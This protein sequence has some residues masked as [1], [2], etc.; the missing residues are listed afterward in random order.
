MKCVTSKSSVSVD[1]IMDIFL[2]PNSCLKTDC[3]FYSDTK[4]S[5]GILDSAHYIIRVIMIILHFNIVWISYL[6]HTLYT[7]PT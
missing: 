4:F 3:K 7:L 6:I 1:L 2:F 5:Q